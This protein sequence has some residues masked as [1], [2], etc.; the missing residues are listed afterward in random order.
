MDEE[1]EKRLNWQDALEFCQVQGA[2]LVSIHSDEEI[3]II[4][5]LVLQQTNYS[6]VYFWIGLN[7]LNQVYQWT[8]GSP[9]NF[10]NWDTGE[11]DHPQGF[12]NCAE[13]QLYY[14]YPDWNN[15]NCDM[16][17]NF[18]CKIRK[19]KN[20]QPLPTPPQPE[21]NEDPSACGNSTDGTWIRYQEPDTGDDKCYMFIDNITHGW[22][23]AENDCITKGGHLVAI[24]SSGEN[25]F[26]LSRGYQTNA[27]A[28][29]IGL[30]NDSGNTFH[31]ADGSPYVYTNWSPGEPNNYYDSEG[32]VTISTYDGLWNDDNCGRKF[33]YVCEKMMGSTGSKVD[34]TPQAT[35]NCPAGFSPYGN[36][37]YVTGGGKTNTWDTAREWCK[38]NSAELVTIGNEYEQSFLNNYLYEKGSTFW[39]G[40]SDRYTGVGQF[41]WIDQSEV[42]YTNWAPGEPDASYEG[43]AVISPSND[44]YWADADCYGYNQFVCSV[45]KS[46]SNPAPP[47]TQS[48][49]GCKNG[50]LSSTHEQACY[51]LMDHAMSWYDARKACQAEGSETDLM[52]VTNIYDNDLIKSLFWRDVTSGD[53]M[54]LGMSFVIQVTSGNGIGSIQFTWTD[55]EPLMYTNWAVGEPSIDVTA[56]S[57]GCVLINRDGSWFA[58][59]TTGTGV[60]CATSLP[61]VCKQTLG[62]IPTTPVPGT[63]T[64]DPGF[65]AYG[66]YCYLISFGTTDATSRSWYESAIECEERGAALASFHNIEEVQAVI[67]AIGTTPSHNLFIGMSSNEFEIWQWKDGTPADF[68]NWANYEPNGQNGTKCVEMYPWDGTWNDISCYGIRGYICKKY[69]GATT[70]LPRQTTKPSEESTAGSSEAIISSFGQRTTTSETSTTAIS[71]SGQPVTVKEPV[72]GKGITAGAIV[73]IVIAVL[74][75]MVLITGGV[76]IFMG[77]SGKSM[78]SVSM[79]S[80]TMPN[81]TSSTKSPSSNAETSKEF[82]NPMAL[83]DGGGYHSVA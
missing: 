50:Y 24:Q 22:Q 41:V 58:V 30:K 51:K 70:S 34:P 7:N 76:Y 44:G 73:G 27:Q 54:W 18:I 23:Y 82:D 49:I 11:P 16:T 61:F 81:F 69:Q 28:L 13:S 14:H 66:D 33:G 59:P 29:W 79:P 56:S 57:S 21:G 1:S 67:D 32:C 62:T 38:K 75:V 31:W 78:P 60:S 72:T 25:S 9:V 53:S 77:S 65:F 39:I 68:F 8:D 63:G 19:G 37:C 15:L 80:F 35:G 3:T 5:N 45:R 74:V 6:F 71:A 26:V 4:T 55:G 17:R 20:P 46:T 47:N 10:T 12:E 43:C 52:S 48:P 36:N 83:G 64:C 40:L 2:D 42:V